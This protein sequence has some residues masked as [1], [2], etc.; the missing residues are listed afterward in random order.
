MMDLFESEKRIVKEFD[1]ML[2]DTKE[3]HKTVND[4]FDSVS[5]KTDSELEADLLK[6]QS[7]V[8]IL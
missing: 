2:E 8:P 7:G 5:S 6:G 1:D 4:L 3:T